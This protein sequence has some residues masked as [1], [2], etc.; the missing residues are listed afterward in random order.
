[1]KVYHFVDEKYGL[2]DLREKRQK[3]SRIMELNDPFEFLGMELSDPEFRK[4]MKSTK[5]QLAKTKGILCFSETWTNPV[6]WSHY[7]NNH[8]GVCLGF[9]VPKTSLSKVNYIE[10][11]LPHNGKIDE[12]LMI[13]FLTTKFSH[14]SYE[15]EYRAFLSLDKEENGLYYSNFSDSFKLSS[16]IIGAHSKVAKSQIAKTIDKNVEIFKARAA[17]RSFKIVRNKNEDMWA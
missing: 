9:D 15:K 3:I 10:E 11:R 5:K 17:F 12:S 14:W 16:V 2:K 13:K 1:M 4:A 7:A 8:K 6:Q